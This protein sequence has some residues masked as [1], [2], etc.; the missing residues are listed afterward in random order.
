M[1]THVPAKSGA[2]WAAASIARASSFDRRF[3]SL[4]A[5]PPGG[6]GHGVEK[7]GRGTDAVARDP[8]GRGGPGGSVSVKRSPS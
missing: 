6:G 7:R 8:T 4:I 5:H 1:S 3:G 2:A